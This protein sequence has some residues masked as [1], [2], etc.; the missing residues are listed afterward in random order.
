MPELRE[1]FRKAKEEIVNRVKNGVK[2]YSIHKMTC[3]ST[4]WSKGGIGFLVTQKRCDCSLEKALRCCKE[5]WQIVFA[6]SKKC[7]GAESRYALVE[8][9]ALGV[10]YWRRHAYSP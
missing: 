3:L 9:E 8:E 5:G 10:A 1:E 7:S 2:T 6:G 4:D